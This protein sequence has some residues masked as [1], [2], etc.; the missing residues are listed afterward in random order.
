M[1]KFTRNAFSIT[2]LAVAVVLGYTTKVA[3]D[4]VMTYMDIYVR[5]MGLQV[6]I[7][8]LPILVGVAAAYITYR[9]EKV[10]NY[11]LEVIAEVKKVVWPNKKE[12][13]G[14]T[15]VVIIAVIISGIVL[16]LFDW[17]SGLLLSLFLR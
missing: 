7:S 12:T 2:L 14:A 10:R 9:I 15:V 8:I 6:V 11:L 16:G 1:D 17:L 13:W 3:M 5:S 4:R